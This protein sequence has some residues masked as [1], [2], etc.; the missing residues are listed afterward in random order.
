MLESGSNKFY[1]FNGAISI[2]SERADRIMEEVNQLEPRFFDGSMG[3]ADARELRKKYT[4]LIQYYNI[5]KNGWKSQF[6]LSR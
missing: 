6:Y 1:S 4:L 5:S 3:V 2:S